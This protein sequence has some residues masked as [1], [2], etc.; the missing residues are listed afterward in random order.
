MLLIAGFAIV[1]RTLAVA[2]GMMVTGAST[3]DAFTVGSSVTPLGEFSFIIV[4]LGV[5]AGVM[6]ADFQAVAVGVVLITALTAP[7]LARRAG[8]IGEWMEARQPRWLENWLS[9]YRGWL[10]RM[11]ALSKRNQ[12]WQL[13][14]KRVIQVVVE[15]LL[16]TGLLVFSDSLL[17]AV[18]PFIPGERFFPNAPRVLFWSG[19]VLV[20]VAPLFAIWRNV[21]VLAMMLAEVSTQGRP[22]AARLRPMVETGVKVLA[23]LVMFVWLSAVAPVALMG[24]WV[25]LLV[26]ALSV[27]VLV[28]ARHKLIYWHSVLEGELQ[29]RIVAN[30]EKFSATTAPW[31]AQHG[32]WR[33]GLQEVVLPDQADIRGRTIGE[34][35]LRK[36]FGCTVAGVERQGVMVGNPS[37]LT[38]LYPRDKILLLGDAQQTAACKDFLLGVTGAATDSNFDE[39]RMEMFTLPEESWLCSRSLAESAPT[40]HTGVQVAGINRGGRRI[41][42]P[43]G[44]ERFVARDDVLLLGTPDQIKAFKAWAGESAG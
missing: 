5:L 23:G 29:E 3:K 16:V 25:P 15:V 1:G 13:S 7:V 10:E 4:Q 34:L 8:S 33:L 40:R 35:A 28:F 43:S 20:V 12:L 31:L 21:S 14:R 42:N 26:L 11:Q 32:E 2:V 30:D 39:V 19:L 44:D 18:L 36:R 41:L 9:Y 38:A 17:E 6:T 22:N 24:R 27:G 37:P